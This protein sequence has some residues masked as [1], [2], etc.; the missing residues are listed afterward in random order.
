M[1]NTKVEETN[2]VVKWDEKEHKNAIFD[3]VIKLCFNCILIFKIL[4]VKII[5]WN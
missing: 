3:L 4:H 2:T 1:K 5:V